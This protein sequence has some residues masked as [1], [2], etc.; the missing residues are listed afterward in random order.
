MGGIRATGCLRHLES[1]LGSHEMHKS[2]ECCNLQGSLLGSPMAGTLQLSAGGAVQQ[3]PLEGSVFLRERE[4][5]RER[6]RERK[7]ATKSG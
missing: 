2:V 6:Q 4:R 3:T 5:E 7:R 1:M